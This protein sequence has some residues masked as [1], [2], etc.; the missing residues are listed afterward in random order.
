MKIMADFFDG[1]L[2]GQVTIDRDII[3]GQ[4]YGF[5]ELAVMLMG[6]TC[7]WQF[8]PGHRFRIPSPGWLGRESLVLRQQPTITFPSH[9]YEIVESLTADGDVIVRAKYLGHRDF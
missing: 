7:Q 1:P 8:N 5:L 9:E 3:A 6:S 4:S 2:D